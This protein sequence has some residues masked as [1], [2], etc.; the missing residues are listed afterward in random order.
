M[1]IIL[2]L[3]TTFLLA[4]CGSKD[5]GSEQSIS[6]TVDK[7]NPTWDNGIGALVS[8]KC[9]NCH[10]DSRGSFVP[11]NV[12]K[13]INAVNMQSFFESPT[14]YGKGYPF[15]AYR[16]V[17]L[18]PTS[19]MPPLFGTPLNSDEREALRKYLELKGFT[20]QCSV[21]TSNLKYADVKDII[22]SRCATCHYA[23][24][25]VRKGLT[26][27][28]QMRDQRDAA[29]AYLTAKTMPDAAPE[30]AGSADG[31]KLFEWLCG[32]SDLTAVPLKKI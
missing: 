6:V 21:T 24:S 28:E 22:D 2:P 4:H 13:T 7:V 29:I 32:G 9:A 17:F 12:P 26:T 19:P 20:A 16:R 27:I 14:S 3:L 10:I 11:A 5:L 25:P 8:A 30:F 23:G 18:T 1:K 31:K 15:L